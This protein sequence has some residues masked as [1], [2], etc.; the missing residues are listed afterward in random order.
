MP[1]FPDANSGG[2]DPL[3]APKCKPPLWRRVRAWT[4]ILLL[5]A[6]ILGMA[7]AAIPLLRSAFHSG[8]APDDRPMHLLWAAMLLTPL[9]FVVRYF[10][11]VRLKTGR[12]RGTPEQRK[13]DKEQR[14]AKCSTVGGKPVCGSANRN[15]LVTYA[16]R[17][18]SYTAFAPECNPGQRTA[19]WLVLI[20]YTLTLIA[21][22]AFG[23]IALGAAFDSSNTVTAT[24]LF[25]ALGL[26]ALAWPATI[27]WRLA[28]GI[29]NGKVGATREELDALRTQRTAWATRENQKSLRSKLI[30]TAIAAAIYVFWWIR[31][32]VHHAQ[33]PHES[34]ITP[35]MFMPAFIYSI[36][37]QFRRPKNTPPTEN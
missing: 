13:R 30:S 7:S 8:V 21:V 37:V 19:A 35:A 9:G 2:L 10:I 6:M 32:T 33:H 16:I 17:W 25:I 5:Y 31:V 28:R 22:A 11:R 27:A 3:G 29:R 18:A 14:L 23:V 20:T 34:W 1:E 36:W 26:F 15:S 4:I 24:L 12:W